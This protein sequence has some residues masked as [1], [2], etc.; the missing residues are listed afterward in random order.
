MSATTYDANGNQVGSTSGICARCGAHIKHIFTWDG[1]TYGS[2]CIEVVTGIGR[3][4][5][6][7]NGRNLDL[8]ASKA[9]K[10]QAETDKAT[11][12]AAYEAKRQAA[13]EVQQANVKRF[14]EI[15]YLL[16]NSS[17]DFCA[18]VACQI[19]QAEYSTEL[20]NILSDRAFEIVSEIYGKTAG[21]KGSK[22]YEARVNEFY[23]KYGEKKE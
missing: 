23:Q 11:R 19:K 17:G 6:V 22:G 20:Y 21:R 7:F 1:Q 10:A 12:L 13:R 14:E 2:E 4:Y 5:Q 18:S 16:E 15:I 9:R 8:E 3:D